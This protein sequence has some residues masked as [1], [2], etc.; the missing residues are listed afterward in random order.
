MISG[1]RIQNTTEW[2]ARRLDA[3]E[4]ARAGGDAPRRGGSFVKGAAQGGRV[5]FA[6]TT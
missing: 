3:T 6:G 1:R 4:T 2:L 5:K